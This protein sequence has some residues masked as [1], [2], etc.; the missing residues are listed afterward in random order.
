MTFWAPSNSL[1]ELA[2]ITIAIH[3]GTL[4]G[5]EKE[6]AFEVC[7]GR[8]HFRQIFGQALAKHCDAGHEECRQGLMAMTEGQRDYVEAEAARGREEEARRLEGRN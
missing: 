6:G 8:R 1:A 7:E 2:T 4:D 3:G 5:G